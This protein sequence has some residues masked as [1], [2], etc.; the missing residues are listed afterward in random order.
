MTVIHTPFHIWI[1]VF[2]CLL[3]QGSYGAEQTFT[4]QGR[5]M[6][7]TIKAGQQVTISDQCLMK[8]DTLLQQI[9]AIRMTTRPHPLLKRIAGTPGQQVRFIP[10]EMLIGDRQWSIPGVESSV[11]QRQLKHTDFIIPDDSYVVLSDQPV[12]S[13]DSVDF[14]VIAKHQIKGCLLTD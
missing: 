2:F 6:L 9:V 5:S 11:L 14:G 4:V 1:G 10:N 12:D 8:G 7:P 13:V 3:N